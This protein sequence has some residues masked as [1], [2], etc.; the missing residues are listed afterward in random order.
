ME[1]FCRFTFEADGLRIGVSLFGAIL[2]EWR[3]IRA[4]MTALVATL[5]RP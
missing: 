5:Q 3:T 2:P 1:T 4:R